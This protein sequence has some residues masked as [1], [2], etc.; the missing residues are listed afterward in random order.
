MQYLSGFHIFGLQIHALEILR[1][2]LNECDTLLCVLAEH[3]RNIRNPAEEMEQHHICSEGAAACLFVLPD[4]PCLHT[5]L[6]DLNLILLI[7]CREDDAVGHHVADLFRLACCK[8]M[9][10]DDLIELLGG[11]V[12]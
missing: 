4:R 3:C 8:R 11:V 5:G 2:L 12:C 10:L 6:T 7:Q 1:G 9:I